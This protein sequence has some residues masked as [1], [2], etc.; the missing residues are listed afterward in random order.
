MYYPRLGSLQCISIEPKSCTLCRKTASELKTTKEAT[1]RLKY[2]IMV[3]N[4]WILLLLRSNIVAIH[5]AGCA[6]ELDEN[7]HVTSV[8]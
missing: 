6:V 8:P 4:M 5:M 1:S 3:T 7:G 2:G